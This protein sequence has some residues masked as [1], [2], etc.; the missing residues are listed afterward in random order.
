MRY[1]VFIIIAGL[2]PYL[3][4]CHKQE[5]PLTWNA[6]YVIPLVNGSLG[7][8]DLIADSLLS[9][10][11][12][13]SLILV[14]EGKLLDLSVSEFLALPDT[15]ISDTFQLQFPSPVDLS[16]GQVFIN[17]PEEQDLQL[18]GISIANVKILTGI[19][20][21]ELKSSVQGIV[22]YTYEIPSA[23]D[24]QGNI[25]SKTITVPAAVAGGTTIKTGS[26]SL[27]G[28]YLDMQGQSGIGYNK[29]LTNINCKIANSN[30]SDITVSSA[31]L[32]TI[33][34][35]FKDVIIESAEGYFGQHSVSTGLDYA[36]F[37]S[38]SKWISGAI[39]ID[40]VE[41]DLVLKNGIGVDAFIQLNQ[42]LSV[43]NNGSVSLAHSMVGDLISLPRATRFY[44]SI[45]PT[46]FE[47]NLDPSNSNIDDFLEAIPQSIGYNLDVVINPL[48]NV[49]G[50]NDFY[51]M[52]APMGVYLNASLPLR[53]IANDLTLEDTLT[54]SIDESS[55]VNEMVLTIE[56][57]NGF[58][59]EANVEI[60]VLDVNDNVI[61]RIFSPNVISAGTVGSD[62]KVNAS[63]SSIHEIVVDGIDMGRIQ[64]NG[65]LLL[66]V[67]F[68]TPGSDHVS[69]Y[70]SYRLNYKV[71]ADANV[72][73]TVGND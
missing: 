32:I 9:T 20:E 1:F 56:V 8:E 57:E 22:I 51:N 25:F 35:E 65:R 38:F 19:L 18:S 55:S 12:D 59:L 17:M 24:W 73:I 13:S 11:I 39:D 21:Y 34:N 45:A 2:V 29:I 61:S 31:D 33:D 6:D 43:G 37:G 10:D 58:P 40:D 60:G 4:S 47:A 23:T 50:Y 44:D 26:F 3:S 64:T 49:S 42:L 68:N 67:V 28:Y 69:I 16:P 46:I 41:V 71:K 52:N 7:M 66:T 72:K 14:Y 27:D 15:V 5:K 62:G 70:N 48:G 30:T 36:E 54:I 53:F 63:S